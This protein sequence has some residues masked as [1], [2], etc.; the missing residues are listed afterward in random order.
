MCRKLNKCTELGNDPEK[1]ETHTP[2]KTPEWMHLEITLFISAV[3]HFLLGEK[4]LCL[5]KIKQ[6][7]TEEMTKWF[8]EHGQMSGRH[9]KLI[10]ALT[11]PLSIDKSLRDPVRSPIR[12]QNIVFERDGYKCRYC[13]NKLISQDFIRLFI[14]KLDSN[15]FQR[16]E[17]NLKTHGI[18][19]IAWPVA[20]HVVPWAKGGKT[21]LDNLVTS[22]A[23][24]NYGKDGYTI[25]QIKINNPFD[26]KPQ[27]DSWSGLT[28]KI[29][30]LKNINI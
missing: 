21:N 20:D 5:E 9:R 2:L 26:R 28:D 8:I 7:R 6:I 17:T 14:K 19:H 30:Q 22:C 12:L 13:G 1:W 23:A 15:L 4:T 3:E 18:I 29:E 10:L 11:P 24:C 27:L 16:G 25:E